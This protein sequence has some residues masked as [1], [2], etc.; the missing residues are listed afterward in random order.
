MPTSYLSLRFYDDGDGTGKLC[1]RAESGGFAGQGGAY[2]DIESIEEFARSIIEYPLVRNYEISGGFGA[3]AG[4]LAQ[5][6][7]GIS[8]YPIDGRGHIGVQVRMATEVWPDTRPHSEMT[9]KVEIV[10]SHEPLRK[11]SADL[12]SLV[13]G[14]VREITLNG[15]SL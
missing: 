1:A 15:D 14:N 13:R 6:H 7:L 3:R 9:V 4:E 2:F 8:V 5:E 10:T 11:L 12:L